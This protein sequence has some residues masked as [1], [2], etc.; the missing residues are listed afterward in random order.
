MQEHWTARLYATDDDPAELKRLGIKPVRAL[1][2]DGQVPIIDQAG[3]R[4]ALV[5]CQTVYKRGQGHTAECAT[6]D[7]RAQRIANLPATEAA[8]R[9]MLA[10]LKAIKADL[11]TFNL[12]DWHTDDH[13]HHICD[14]DGGLGGACS[15]IDSAIAQAE[16][17]GIKG[18]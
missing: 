4:V 13:P 1:T 8:A 15:E 5:D 11:T 12:W 9:A 17:A 18:E 2:N 10:A 3:Q 6:R 16:A 7:S 14:Q